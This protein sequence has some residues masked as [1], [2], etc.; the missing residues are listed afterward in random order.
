MNQKLT[1]PSFVFGSFHRSSLAGT[2]LQKKLWDRGIFLGK[3]GDRAVFRDD[4][5]SDLVKAGAID[6][7]ECAA[8]HAA[9]R[10]LL[11]YEIDLT[12][13]TNED[14]L[15]AFHRLRLN[16]FGAAPFA[17]GRAVLSGT[18]HVVDGIDQ[19]NLAAPLAARETYFFYLSENAFWQDFLR[20]V[21]TALAAGKR[22]VILTGGEGDGLLPDPSELKELMPEEVAVL[23]APDSFGCLDL[24]RIVLSPESAAAV[25]GEQAVLFGYGEDAL[26][27]CHD[28]ALPAVVTVIPRGIPARAV[29]GLFTRPAVCRL[30]IPAHFSIYPT[31]SLTRRTELSYYQLAYLAERYGEAVYRTPW[32]ELA[33]RDGGVFLNVYDD[34]L[35]LRVTADFS[36]TGASFGADRAA[37][38]KRKLSSLRGI[39]PLHGCFSLPAFEPVAVDWESGEKRAQ[40]LADGVLVSPGTAVKVIPLAE[41]ASPRSLFFDR[42]EKG[43]AVLSNFTFF[44]TEK[45]LSNYNG[46]L[47]SRPREQ[48]DFPVGTLDY[49]RYTDESGRRHETLPLYHKAVL[50]SHPDGFYAFDFALG[51]GSATLLPGLSVRWEREQVNAP[52]PQ[53]SVYTPLFSR[54]QEERDDK[55]F[56][57]PVGEGRLN[58]AVI[59][60][61]ILCIR[62]GDVAL[63]CVGTVF[64]LDGET[65]RQ[66]ERVLGAPDENGYYPVSDLPSPAFRP[67][68]PEGFPVDVWESLSWAYG[69]GL[70]LIGGGEEITADTYLEKFRAAGWLSPLSRQTQESRVHTMARHPRTVV[71]VTKRNELFVLVVSGR[72]PV[73]AGAD[74]LELCRLARLLVPDTV[75]LINWDGGGSSVLG[76]LE[77]DVFTELSYP[78]PSDGS[79]TGM[80]R[81]V[82]S[83]LFIKTE[84]GE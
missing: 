44:F 26:L 46:R 77:N 19:S 83:L 28:L 55:D 51:G 35:P 34:H 27:A 40:V 5:V 58:V 21:R 45:L 22:V 76:L 68:A 50:A 36:F 69:G 24:S 57:C 66:A 30:L 49:Y 56:L 64:S 42:K 75:T 59:G 32:Q 53:L 43:S 65:A 82:S 20:D 31:V 73:S 72:T 81:P 9:A 54:S 74:Y 41:S 61:K 62:R 14:I 7:K 71:G 6:G 60:E 70:G 8:Y 80:A 33:R 38:C 4:L 23:S 52:H 3:S 25:A 1:D 16:R 79:I 63:P 17:A 11:L 10:D 29:T 47:A 13:G 2:L 12:A 39:T 37:W 67:D 48:I 78:A 18:P 15:R 84:K